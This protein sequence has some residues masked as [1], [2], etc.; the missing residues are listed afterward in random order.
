M[1]QGSSSGITR[2]S[3]GRAVDSVTATSIQSSPV[4]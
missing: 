2:A 4:L 1:Y 3:D